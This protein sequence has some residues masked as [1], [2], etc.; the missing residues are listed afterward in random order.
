MINQLFISEPEK[1]QRL[2]DAMVK[3]LKA[4]VGEANKINL[5]KIVDGMS[6]LGCSPSLSLQIIEHIR[7]SA[8]I[9]NLIIDCDGEYTFLYIAE[10]YDLVAFVKEL[11]EESALLTTKI[12]NYE[13]LIEGFN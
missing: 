3:Y 2:I 11:K 1:H 10:R 4:K 7:S 5:D 13:T 6:K 8:L 9:P 12:G